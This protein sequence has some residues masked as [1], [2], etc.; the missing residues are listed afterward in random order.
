MFFLLQRN[1]KT[2]IQAAKMYLKELGINITA[3]AVRIKDTVRK[4]F[5]DR[6]V[7]HADGTNFSTMSKSFKRMPV[8]QRVIAKPIEEQK[9]NAVSTV[10]TRAPSGY[11]R[12]PGGHDRKKSARIFAPSIGRVVSGKP[13]DKKEMKKKKKKVK[14]ESDLEQF[15]DDE[16]V[17]PHAR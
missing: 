8:K 12:G 10:T 2:T 4:M 17:P 15:S 11:V 5:D 6:E 3:N 16:D 7:V 9:V 1:K 14:D 13:T